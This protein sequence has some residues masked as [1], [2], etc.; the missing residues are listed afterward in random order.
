MLFISEWWPGTRKSPSVSKPLDRRNSM[1]SLQHFGIS[2]PDDESTVSA[3]RPPNNLSFFFFRRFFFLLFFSSPSRNSFSESMY[4]LKNNRILPIAFLF[5]FVTSTHACDCLIMLYCFSFAVSSLACMEG[6][7]MMR[8]SVWC[9]VNS[10]PALSAS[11]K[12]VFFPPFDVVS[13]SSFST[14]STTQIS[15]PGAI[16]RPFVLLMS[17]VGSERR[18][19]TK[20]YSIK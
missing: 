18:S 16:E 1:S 9:V 19:T 14:L 6:R 4:S 15:V 3:R 13:L 10:Q 12:N 20:G 7:A 5:V 8:P 17:V 11:R 2:S